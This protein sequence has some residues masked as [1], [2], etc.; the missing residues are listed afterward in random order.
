LQSIIIYI[1][2]TSLLVLS[3]L[4]TS[5]YGMKKPL[6]FAEK[7]HLYTSE[8]AEAASSSRCSAYVDRFREQSAWAKE[9]ADTILT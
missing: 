7:A 1:M 3:L 2:K 9:N 4:L 8:Y 5:T 6:M